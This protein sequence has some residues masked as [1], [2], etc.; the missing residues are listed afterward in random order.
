MAD[1][2]VNL[3]FQ[4]SA[5]RHHQ[6]LLGVEKS[7][8]GCLDSLDDL[9]L[10]VTAAHVDRALHQPYQ[11]LADLREFSRADPSSDL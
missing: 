6:R 10:S 4:S 3:P 1:T 5:E 7:L 8:R 9:G 11:D 2:P